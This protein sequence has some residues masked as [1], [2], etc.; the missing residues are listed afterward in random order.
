MVPVRGNG[1]SILDAFAAHAAVRVPGAI[2]RVVA[3]GGASRQ[4]GMRGTRRFCP[5]GPDRRCNI[6][7][8]QA[9]GGEEIAQVVGCLGPGWVPIAVSI[10]TST[11]CDIA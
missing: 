2:Q 6:S 7:V 4:Q 5:L 10:E 9:H 3:Q 8:M 1:A 11:S